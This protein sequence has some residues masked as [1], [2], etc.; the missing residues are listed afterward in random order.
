LV[1]RPSENAHVSFTEAS[2]GSGRCPPKRIV[3]FSEGSNAMDCPTLGEGAVE[4]LS[5]SQFEGRP[6]VDRGPASTARDDRSPAAGLRGEVPEVPA[7]ELPTGPWPTDERTSEARGR[8]WVPATLPGARIPGTRS[9]RQM[10]TSTHALAGPR[11]AGIIRS[12]DGPRTM[13][14]SRW[15]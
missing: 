10:A 12:R 13:N 2:Y 5:C 3:S 6:E 1:Q 8:A 15:L 11:E 4:G 14:L 7:T 9:V